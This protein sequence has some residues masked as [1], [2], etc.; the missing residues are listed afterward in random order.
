MPITVSGNTW[1]D[2]IYF[3]VPVD[4]ELKQ[5]QGVVDPEDLGYW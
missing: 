1:G 3:R 5:G 4:T 2:E